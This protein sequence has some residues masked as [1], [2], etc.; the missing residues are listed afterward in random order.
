ML[1]RILIIFGF[2]ISFSQNEI[3]PQSVLNNSL[4]LSDSFFF[5]NNNIGDPI[6]LLF[7]KVTSNDFLLNHVSQNVRRVDFF[8][9]NFSTNNDQSISNMY[10]E[11]CY[12]EGGLIKGSL[13]R[14]VG[15]NIFLNFLYHNLS[16]TGYYNHQKNKY[17]NLFF[18]LDFF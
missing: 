7:P 16:S 2:Y 15:K 1:F 3:T 9:I 8:K 17:S 6:V 10:Y 14:P 12:N 11:S 18:S 13:S 5:E 4:D